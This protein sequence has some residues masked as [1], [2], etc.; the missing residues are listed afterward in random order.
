[1]S[2]SGENKFRAVMRKVQLLQ[3]NLHVGFF[4]RLLVLRD[5][6]AQTARMLAVEGA[7]NRF[8]QRSRLEI[9]RQHRRPR[10]GLKRHP[11]CA[12]CRQDGNDHQHLAKF[13]EHA[14]TIFERGRGVKGSRSCGRTIPACHLKNKCI[15]AGQ[16]LET[17]IE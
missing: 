5:F 4:F 7:L 15:D 1:M 9:L 6:L 17:A 16:F 12:R 13:A 8:L 3:I 2:R 14:H 10:D 11:M